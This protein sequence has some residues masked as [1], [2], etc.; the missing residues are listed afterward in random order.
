MCLFHTGLIFLCV[1]II[2]GPK[3]LTLIIAYILNFNIFHL[4]HKLV[5]IRLGCY[6][7][8]FFSSMCGMNNI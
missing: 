8:Y 6:V 2:E 4:F 7:S 1:E 3:E 5:F